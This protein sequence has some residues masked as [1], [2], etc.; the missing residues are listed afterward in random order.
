MNEPA[1]ES[2]TR[3]T[4]TVLAPEQR[5]EF[6]RASRAAAWVGLYLPLGISA[7]ATALTLIW[8]PRL[9]NPAATHWSTGSHPDGFGPSWSLPLLAALLGLGITLIMWVVVRMSVRSTA[10]PVWSSFQRFI[11]AFGF[12]T[13]LFGEVIS[14]GSS[15]IQLDV[16]DA[17]D[18]PGIGLVMVVG[19]GVWALATLFAW[20]AQPNVTIVRQDSTPSE[21]LEL[22]DTERAVWIG[23]VRPSRVFVWVMG[24]ALLLL[25]G[26]TVWSFSIDPVAGWVSAG[27][28]VL[29]LVLTALNAWFRVR[30]D[31][32][33][34]EAR[35]LFGWPVFRVPAS[36]VERVEA[37]QINPFAE[38]GGWGLRWVPGRLGLVMRAGEGLIVTRK[39]GRVFGASIDDAET[40][41]A[42]LAAAAKR[43]QA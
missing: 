3:S 11:A 39:G 21:P 41:A 17:R 5:A 7:V 29:A 2:G 38:F 22:A 33:G 24:I 25:L 43:A 35:A 20:L 9:P 13:V 19:F 30:I 1:N 34:L 36:D 18:V 32:R 37:A 23:E 10:A 6:D 26:T 12:G 42:V 40:A 15:L 4:P 28:L 16:A 27:A 31:D 8:L 14:V